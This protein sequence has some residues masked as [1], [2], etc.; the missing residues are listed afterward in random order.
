MTKEEFKKKWENY[1]YHHKFG[2]WVAI[3]LVACVIYTV[4]E[5]STRTPKDMVITY[6][7]TYA[8][9]IGIAEEIQKNFNDDIKDINSDGKKHIAVTEILTANNHFEG[10]MAFWQR[11]DISFINGESYLYFVDEGIYHIL[12]NRNCL[13]KI[14]TKEGKV[15]FVDVTENELFNK[16]LYGDTKLYLCVRKNVGTNAKKEIKLMEENSRKVLEKILENN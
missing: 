3:F 16:Y 6:M 1:W 14:E 8:D 9:Y 5:I 4:V 7:G 12:K 15:E 2:T 11:A 10:D 13:G